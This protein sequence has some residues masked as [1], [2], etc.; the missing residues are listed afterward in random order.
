M[1]RPLASDAQSHTQHHYILIVFTLLATIQADSKATLAQKTS[2]TK[3][4]EQLKEEP[5]R[6][7]G[8]DRGRVLIR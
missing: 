5:K 7:G 1:V 3:R 6:H 8:V 4:E 2:R